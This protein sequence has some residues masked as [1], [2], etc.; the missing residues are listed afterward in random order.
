MCL[1]EVN[2]PLTSCP[3]SGQGQ[4]VCIDCFPCSGSCAP[5]KKKPHRTKCGAFIK[6]QEI[7][8]LSESLGQFRHDLEQVANK[9]VVRNLKHRSLSILVDRHDHLA[10]LHTGEMLDRTGN[11]DSNI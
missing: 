1:V 11:T 7:D 10:V 2:H 6:Y 8:R 9:G 5:K 4:P 3:D